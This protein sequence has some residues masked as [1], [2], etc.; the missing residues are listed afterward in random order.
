MA[1]SYMNAYARKY[2]SDG[3]ATRENW[4]GPSIAIGPLTTLPRDEQPQL[5]SL[6]RPTVSSSLPGAGEMQ[7]RICG[8]GLASASA[9]VATVGEVHWGVGPER[10]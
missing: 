2:A 7:R 3:G 8:Q 10:R 6:D 9:S 4:T 5:S 1:V